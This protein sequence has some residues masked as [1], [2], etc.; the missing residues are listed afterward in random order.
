MSFGVNPAMSKTAILVLL[1]AF[2][3]GCEGSMERG[4]IEGTV[5]R[6]DHSTGGAL[7]VRAVRPEY[8]S[9]IL[10]ADEVGS[11][12]FAGL[13]TGRWNVEFFDEAGWQVGLETVT[14]RADETVTLDSTIGEESLPRDLVPSRLINA[15]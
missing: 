8:P 13:L 12:H 1:F 11:Y 15:P 2:A 9:V 6:Q 3:L 7:S 5:Y 10:R 4:D 14:V